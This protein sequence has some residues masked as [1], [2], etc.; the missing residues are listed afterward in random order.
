MAAMPKR[1]TELP[2]DDF[3]R[4]VG[5]RFDRVDHR[6]DLVD[7]RFAAGDQRFDR[8]ESLIHVLRSETIAEFRA[9]RAE[10]AAL[11]RTFVQVAVGSVVTIL[12]GFGAT[13]VTL[14]TQL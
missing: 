12:V 1:W 5:R 6:F 11:N 3:R 2:I 8:V 4:N 9:I 14:A 7:Q 10:M 13:I